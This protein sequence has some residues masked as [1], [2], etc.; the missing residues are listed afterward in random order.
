VSSRIP[1]AIAMPNWYSSRIGCVISTANVPARI[2][3]AEDTTPPVRVIAAR[4]AST[5]VRCS[6]SCRYRLMMKML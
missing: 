3:P 5:G 6:D 2:S 4:S 1:I